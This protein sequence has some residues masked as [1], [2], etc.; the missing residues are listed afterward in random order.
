MADFN[1]QVGATAD[2][3]GTLDGAWNTDQHWLSL[4]YDWSEPDKTGLRFLNVTIPKDATILTAKLSLKATNGNAQT[5]CSVKIYAEDADDA[6]TFSTEANFDG[7][8]K[9]PVAGHAWTN[10]GEWV[11]DTWY[12]SPEIVQAIQDVVNRAGWVSGQALAI[13]IF[14]DSSDEAAARF[15]HS[16]DEEEAGAAK[17]IVTYSVGGKTFSKCFMTG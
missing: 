10:I 11:N 1:G 9:T 12:D 7:R 17:L 6:A 15:F 4:G 8:S 13:L 5:T 16:F 3:A 14:D 2:D